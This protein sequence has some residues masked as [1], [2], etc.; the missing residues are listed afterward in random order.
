MLVAVQ[1]FARLLLASIK[2]SMWGVVRVVADYNVR[3]G[4]YLRMIDRH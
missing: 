4:H 3:A 2:R 1:R